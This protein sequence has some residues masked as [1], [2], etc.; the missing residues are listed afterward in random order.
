MA[1]LINGDKLD[2]MKLQEL[3]EAECDARTN[4]QS[5]SNRKSP[6][7]WI[8]ADQ[9]GHEIKPESIT[10]T[11]RTKANGEILY[12]LDHFSQLYYPEVIKTFPLNA[13]TGS[14]ILSNV[15]KAYD[16]LFNDIK[17]RVSCESCT[18]ICTNECLNCTD[19]CGFSCGNSS[20][21]GCAGCTGTCG[22][23][24]SKCNGCTGTCGGSCSVECYTCY[25]KC[26]GGSSGNGLSCKTCGTSRCKNAC[27]YEC[28]QC[29]SGCSGGCGGTC[30]SGCNG[31]NGCGNCQYGCTTDCGNDCI[32]GCSSGCNIMCTDLVK[33][34]GA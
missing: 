33:G 1:D 7:G 20:C 3:I 5:N 23:N 12:Y 29:C 8:F 31:C 16:K 10:P 32:G 27:G 11:K 4:A 9:Y 15:Y 21:K 28:S 17:N 2:G 26:T 24:C 34:Y 13:T 6:F 22:N 18:G 30:T 19:M 25:N 14:K